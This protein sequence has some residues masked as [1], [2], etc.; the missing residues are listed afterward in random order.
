MTPTPPVPPAGG[1]GAFFLP[2]GGARG[3]RRGAAHRALGGAAGAPRS[4]DRRH[5]PA[6]GPGAHGAAMT[7]RATAGTTAWPIRRIRRRAAMHKPDDSGMSIAR[8]SSVSLRMRAQPSLTR[9]R[10]TTT[11]SPGAAGDPA[12]A[13][14][15]MTVS[16]ILIAPGHRPDTAPLRRTAGGD[17]KEEWKWKM[18]VAL[19][20]LRPLRTR[21]TPPATRR[22]ATSNAWWTSAPTRR[23]SQRSTTTTPGCGPGVWRGSI[24]QDSCA[25]SRETF[26]TSSC[27]TTGM[28]MRRRTCTPPSSSSAYASQNRSAAH[29]H[30]FHPEG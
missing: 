7:A 10:R 4:G 2:A 28:T 25:S 14:R 30:V 8:R 23:C 13:G 6:A 21:R 12:C 5:P 1:R 29:R 26:P 17:Q 9:R 11:V 20:P 19:R 22:R 16:G 18:R 15:T 24:P 3:A 27:G